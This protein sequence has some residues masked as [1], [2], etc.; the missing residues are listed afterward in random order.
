[1][2][3]ITIDNHVKQVDLMFVPIDLLI[4]HE[5]IDQNHLT[6]ILSSISINKI[7]MKPIIVEKNKFIVI[8]GHHRL[9]A[10]KIL[11]I[12]IV[13][14]Y[15]AEYGVDIVDVGGWMYVGRD[16]GEDY[17]I[18]WRN[19]VKFVEELESMSK[20]GDGKLV[21]RIRG[22]TVSV[23]IDRVDVY[24]AFKQLYKFFDFVYKLKKIPSDIDKCFSSD[25]C[26]FLPRLKPEDVYRI[27]AKNKILPPRTTF[28]KTY[29]KH[30]YAVYPLKFLQKL[31]EKQWI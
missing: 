31:G 19:V 5:D 3:K 9:N 29:L 18:G 30:L 21:A 26:I 6:K 16:V 17:D 8:D 24:I 15:L 10:L 22:T 1:M 7:L 11:G 23:N 12:K 20:K 25:L 28:H 4:S 14:V 13:P 27:V 2:K